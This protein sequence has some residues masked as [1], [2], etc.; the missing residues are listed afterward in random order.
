MGAT[1]TKSLPSVPPEHMANI[2]TKRLSFITYN[3][4]FD[5]REFKAR[6]L[7]ILEIIREKNADVVCLQEVVPQFIKDFLVK[8]KWITSNYKISDVDGM[9]GGLLVGTARVLCS[10]LCCL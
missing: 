8:D 3:I 1:V 4:W 9:L 10:A 5:P 6:N 7:K 2:A